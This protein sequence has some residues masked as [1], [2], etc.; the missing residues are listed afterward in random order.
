MVSEA[1]VIEQ[2]PRRFP[3]G[4]L[5]LG[6]I[7]III[8]AWFLAAQFN[9]NG[10]LS[11]VLAGQVVCYVLMFRRPVWAFA[12]LIV[13]QLTAAGF[14]IGLSET[15]ILTIR[16]LWTVLTLVLL[17]PV[18]RRYGAI[19]LGPRARRII[20][21][22][23]IFF[24]WAIVANVVNTNMATTLQYARTAAT[25]LVILFL[26]P[27]AI[28]NEKDV[29]IVVVVALVAGAASALVAVMQHYSNL[30]L[31][32]WEI[33]EGVFHQGRTTGL[34]ETPIQLAYN[35]PI[36]VAPLIAIYFIRA[37]SPRVRKY[38]LLIILIMI[39][40][41]FFTYTRSGMYSLA[42]AF[43]IMILLLKGK[44][45]KELFLITLLLA[46]SF[47]WY[48]D[49]KGNRYSKGFTTER[50]A[51]GRLVLWEAG[52][53]I[54]LDNPVFGIGS[55]KFLGEASGYK[56]AVSAANLERLGAGAAL[57]TEKPHNDFIRV[58]LSYGTVAFIAFIV[59]LIGIFRNFLEVYRRAQNKFIK[60]LAIGCLGALGSYIVNAATHNFMDS[61]YLLWILAGLSIGMT[62]LVM[63]R[64]AR[65][66]E[67]LP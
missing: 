13:G 23:I 61:A 67:V 40:G 1:K 62:K 60:G 17:I 16:F 5:L 20:M 35:L 39:M 29:R 43:L 45:K 21:P 51:A 63:S 28:R 58:W 55:D 64:K 11:V 2:Q 12:A 19:K 10:P 42:P 57:G 15:S 33:Y 32:S 18:I 66:A 26:L 14:S 37:T 49:M 52:V 65:K 27:A 59:A 7:A 54:A 6:A 34:S 47:F 41:I 31:P 9:F 22:A 50:S 30:G 53:K 38:L 56:E 8:I 25:A 3:Y 46:V 24:L 48:S 4:K 36:V 44:P